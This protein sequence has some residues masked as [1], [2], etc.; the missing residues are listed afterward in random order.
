MRAI[1][2]SYLPPILSTAFIILMCFFPDKIIDKLPS[3][4][5]M[6]TKLEKHSYKDYIPAIPKEPINIWKLSQLEYS[7]KEIEIKYLNDSNNKSEAIEDIIKKAKEITGDG[8]MNSEI[9]HKMPEYL[10]QM[11]KNSIISR[12]KGFFSFVNIIWMIAI[13]GVIISIVPAIIYFLQPLKA[14]LYRFWNTILFPIII[15]LYEKRI[16]EFLGYIISILLI[17]DG[18]KVN[19]EWGFFI[20][21]T[22]AGF[23]IALFF[24][25]F[26]SI[27]STD[28]ERLAVHKYEDKNYSEK[29]DKNKIILGILI[30]LIFFS[31]SVF[32]NSKLFS[33]MAT[34]VFYYLIGFYTGCFGLCYVIGFLKDSDMYKVITTSFF[35]ISFYIVIKYL[36]INNKI[37]ELYRSPIQIFGAL[38]YFLGLLI[39]ASSNYDKLSLSF[40]QRQIL[41]VCSL[42]IFLFFGLFFNL[43]SLTNTTYVFGVLFLMEKTIEIFQ[44]IKGNIWVLILLLSA[45]L[46][47]FS[48]YLHKHSEIIISIMKGS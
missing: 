42:L 31:L 7:L 8:L 1:F 26:K 17:A 30:G 2:F 40:T 23:I 5:K 41:Y 36:N 33:F 3:I 13:L 11:D 29:S 43:P 27:I 45:S 48:L 14:L 16:F 39:I 4:M 37:I 20:S 12:I 10:E 46:W 44:K 9:L 6:F 38:T 24:Y 21:F 47:F 34:M 32:F 18:M 19:K 25:T 28:Y 15:F 22:G 35:L